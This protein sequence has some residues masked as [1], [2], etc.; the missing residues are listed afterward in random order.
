MGTAESSITVPFLDLA[1]QHQPLQ[2]ELRQAF[3]RVLQ[4]QQFVLGPEVEALERE[5]AAY[6]G[7]PAAVAVSSGTDALLA[8]LMALGVGPG[9]EVIVPT[10]TFF[11][12]AGVVARLHARP[13]FADVEPWGFGIRTEEV[14][15]CYSARTKVVLLVHLYGQ[16]APEVE[17]IRRLCQ[18]YGI[19]LVE[20]AAQAF[21]AQYRDGRGVGQFGCAAAVSF[22]PTKNLGAWGD[23]GMIVTADG[24]LAQRLRLLRN[25]GMAER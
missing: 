25:H 15:R 5:C 3:E 20:D 4:T 6:V 12:T 24:E 13:V 22:Y 2:E 10:W 11:A 9:D 8:L 14:E 18:Q 21:G 1:L 23:A 19:T 7:L 16:I 17:A